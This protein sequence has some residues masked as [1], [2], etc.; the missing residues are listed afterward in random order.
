[1]EFLARLYDRL[2]P[3][4]RCFLVLGSSRGEKAWYWSRWK[5]IYPALGEF[6]SVL[7]QDASIHSRQVYKN[8]SA[9]K[10]GRLSWSEEGHQKWCH[11][12]PLTETQ[13]ENW[14]F[15]DAEV[16][17]PK[18]RTLLERRGFPFPMAY[19]QLSPE[20]EIDGSRR[21]Y[22][23]EVLL[24]VRL[25]KYR[26]AQD[27]TRLLLQKIQQQVNA[28]QT[29]SEVRRVV[30]LNQFESIRREDSMYLGMYE[31]PLPD[32]T[33]M[34]GRWTLEGGSAGDV[35]HAVAADERPC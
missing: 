30:S 17:I 19:V 28:I 13:C 11:Y 2:F 18:R 31:D 5:R 25:D 10:L 22:D 12:S 20:V 32:L 14:T 34:K 27:E 6:A 33:K 21:S 15:V 24:C 9:V 23:Q 29:L 16:F 26:A 35:E 3:R 7:E 8:S 4:Y 1:M